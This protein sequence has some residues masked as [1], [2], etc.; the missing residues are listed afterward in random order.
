MCECSI[1]P[2]QTPSLVTQSRDSIIIIEHDVEWLLLL[3][4]HFGGP[5]S[6]SLCVQNRT[7]SV[8]VLP[9]SYFLFTKNF[10]I[11]AIESIESIESKA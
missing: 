3:L 7:T 11:D 8:H 2:I 10:S 4:L 6:K 9:N 5:E 1:N